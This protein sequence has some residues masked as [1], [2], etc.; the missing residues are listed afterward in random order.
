MP[1]SLFSRQK[2][3]FLAFLVLCLLPVF[4]TPPTGHA[5]Y[6]P[7]DLKRAVQ[8]QYGPAATLIQTGK[9]LY[10]W[11]A[12]VQGRLFP[13][14]LRGA[15]KRQYGRGWI[16]GAVG[17]HKYDWRAIPWSGLLNVVLPV[18]LVSSDHFRQINGVRRGVRLFNSV[19]KRVRDWYGRRVGRSFRLFEPLVLPVRGNAAHWNGLCRASLDNSRRFDFMHEA[20]AAYQSSLPPPGGR[21][22]VVT[23]PYTG[24]SPEIW[25]G[26]A[27]R[28]DFAVTP[29]KER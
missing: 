9:H 18:M 24:N 19:L 11:K 27:S 15:V 1:S 6:A 28:G 3:S 10:D 5:R 26:A 13:L 23:T 21:V 16:L 22:K 14:D 17:V 4:L 25:M 8:E 7:L 12:R 20:I 29:P 2:T